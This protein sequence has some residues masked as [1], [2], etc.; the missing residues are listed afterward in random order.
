MAALALP[1][2]AG[3]LYLALASAPQNHLIINGAALAAALLWAAFGQGPSTLASARIMCGLL[4]ALL[5]IPL[6][7]GPDIIGVTRWLPVGPFMLN[8]GTL[9]F[10]ALAVLSARDEQ[11]APA[12]LLLALFAALLQPDAAL[13]FAITFA[14]AGLHDVTKDWRIGLVTI[15]G[16]IASILMALRG[17]LPPQPFV[18]R[19]LID[20]LA[21]MPAVA[22]LLIIS[23]VG[24]FC[25]ILFG[26]HLPRRQR[27]AL[28]GAMFGFVITAMMSNYP[29]ILIGYGAAPILGFGLA[30]GLAVRRKK[31]LTI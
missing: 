6:I 15:I 27:F 4:L 13:G 5:Y 20:A 2:L 21:S 11:Y 19:V 24:S 12:I 28:A 25:L 23:L 16:F 10:P 14:A 26:I 1:V 8:A 7:T 3:L 30:F 31:D 17:E 29:S 9:A 22:S 18:E